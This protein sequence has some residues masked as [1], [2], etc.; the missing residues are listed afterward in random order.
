[1]ANNIRTSIPTMTQHKIKDIILHR[2]T[3]FYERYHNKYYTRHTHWRQLKIKNSLIYNAKTKNAAKFCYQ[4][5]NVFLIDIVKTFIEVM[6][7]A[8]NASSAYSLIL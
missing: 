3:K 1:M 5:K 4:S 6:L 7:K 2:A 8:D